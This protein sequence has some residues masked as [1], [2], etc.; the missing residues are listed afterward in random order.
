MRQTTIQI[1]TTLFTIIFVT[2]FHYT[3]LWY[4]SCIAR[5]GSRSFAP[6]WFSIKLR[7]A[8]R[9]C[10][11]LVGFDHIQSSWHRHRQA[12]PGTCSM[13]RLWRCWSTI[14]TSMRIHSSTHAALVPLWSCPA[15][16]SLEKRLASC[17]SP[18]WPSIQDTHT[19]IYIYIYTYIYI[20]I[21]IY[22]VYNTK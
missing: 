9:A 3:K 6:I 2:S 1:H 7:H 15:L 10:K 17:A 20:Y 14:S 12:S 22:I 5:S 8:F 4:V 11:M 18:S 13:L 16:F 19:H 21:Y